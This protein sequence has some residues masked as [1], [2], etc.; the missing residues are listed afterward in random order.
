M[1]FICDCPG[2]HLVETGL[3]SGYPVFSVR[4]LSGSFEA[5]ADTLISQALA[6]FDEASVHEASGRWS[7]GEPI[8]REQSPSRIAMMHMLPSCDRKTLDLRDI[9]HFGANIHHL[10]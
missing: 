3:V 4:A 9:P 8:R 1:I 2:F 6:T 10:T 7:G 5:P